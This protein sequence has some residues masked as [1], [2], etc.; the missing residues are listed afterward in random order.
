MEQ[1]RLIV[2]L[3]N[4]GAK[5]SRTR[6]N[7]GFRLVEKL[8]EDWRGA[9]KLEKRFQSELA[10]V[11]RGEMAVLLSRPQTFMNASGEAVAAVTGFY[12]VPLDRL[13]VAVDDAD[14]PLAKFGL[15]GGGRGGG[16][17][18]RNSMSRLPGTKDFAR[19]RIGIGRTA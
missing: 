12:R 4:P 9:W 13:V 16:H 7:V 18:G 11:S 15:R 3:G 10:R 1:L 17:N 2:G 14:L 8:A 6:H 5:Y 19:L